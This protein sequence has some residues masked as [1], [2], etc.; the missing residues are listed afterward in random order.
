M[1]RFDLNS[2]TWSRCL[3]S[4]QYPSP[5]ALASF[6]RYKDNL[7]LFGG[8]SHPAPYP[9]MQPWRIF[10]ELHIYNFSTNRW[11]QIVTAYSPH[12]SAGHSA[13]IHKDKMIVFGGR[14]FDQKEQS[15]PISKSVWMF[16]FHD[17]EWYMVKTGDE[18]PARYGQTQIDIDDSHVL[19]IGGCGGPNQIF[20]DVWL[21]H[22]YKDRRNKYLGTWTEVTINSLHSAIPNDFHYSGCKIGSSV[23]FFERSSPM[24]PFLAFLQFDSDSSPRGGGT[25]SM[26]NIVFEASRSQSQTYFHSRCSSGLRHQVTAS[27]P[28]YSLDILKV[29]TDNCVSW[30]KESSPR[31]FR[32]PNERLLYSMVVG[33][34]EIILFGGFYKEHNVSKCRVS[35]DV[36]V[37]KTVHKSY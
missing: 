30:T 3:A 20:S 8:W 12:P 1:W 11:S 29:L 35:N 34:A 28:M 36:F 21:L 7:V 5:K 26:E 32:R 27:M 13:S 18:I 24:S 2:R 31:K 15:Y 9:L 37:L 14:T 19:I 25:H 22:F 33:R 10:D 4:G 23:I 16:D 17:Q 6:V